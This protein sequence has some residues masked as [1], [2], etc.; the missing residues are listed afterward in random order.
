MRRP[1]GTPVIALTLRRDRIDNFWFTLIHEC[2]HVSKHLNENGEAIFD[3]LEVSSSELIEQ[4][5]DA[6]AVTALIPQHLWD[7]FNDGKFTSMSDVLEFARRAEVHPAIVAGRWQMRN[8]DFRKFS[9]LLG[10]GKV[11]AEFPD[12]PAA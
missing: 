7:S 8:R 10:H 1:D 3:D 11:R 4:E 2:V 9:K 12:F 6:D 5:A